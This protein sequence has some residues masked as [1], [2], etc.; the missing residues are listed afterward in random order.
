MGAN[1]FAFKGILSFIC[2]NEVFGVSGPVMNIFSED[3]KVIRRERASR[4]Y[5]GYHAYYSKFISEFIVN[6]IFC[7]PYNIVVYLSLGFVQNSIVFFKFIAIMLSILCYSISWG[8]TISTLVL[9]PQAA[10]ALGVT[11]SV[12][13][14]LYSGIFSNPDSH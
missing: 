9:S 7:I 13:F 12:T 2:Q 5:S 11:F 3:K 8:L 14:F 10:Q 1:I 6:L 4:F